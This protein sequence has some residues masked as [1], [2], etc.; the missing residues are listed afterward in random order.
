M[1]LKSKLTIATLLVAGLFA[2]GCSQQQAAGSQ[3]TAS[4][5]QTT[6]GQQT[7]TPEPQPV[8]RPPVQRPRPPVQQR[9]PVMPPIKV[10]PVKAKGNYRGPVQMDQSARGMMQQYQR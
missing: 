8:Q 3:Q 5:Q 9:P 2:T 1:E 7:A 6:S 10:P 4:S